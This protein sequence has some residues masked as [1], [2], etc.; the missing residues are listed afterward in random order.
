MPAIT[1]ARYKTFLTQGKSIEFIKLNEFELMLKNVKHK[2]Q[3]QARALFIMLYFTG[4][5]PAEIL[6]L[7]PE[8]ITKQRTHINILFPTKK[9]GI[10]SNL[11]FPLTNPYF[12][13]F[14]DYAN[15]AGFPGFK[16]FWAF[17]GKKGGGYYKKIV[18]WVI[19]NGEQRVKEYPGETKRL[20]YWV[21][22]WC[23]I[24]PYFFRHN[25]FSKMMLQGAS[26]ADVMH[27]KGAKGYGSIFPYIGYSKKMAKRLSKY[28][29]D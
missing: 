11:M 16:I 27:A 3:Q 24:T 22:K 5:R 23:G 18:K 1:D 6:E 10:V 28:Y 7:T 8:L 15:S 12:K 4:R 21:K 2:H 19:R 9:G 13:E 25:R 20:R 14:W 17:R 29:K 26:F